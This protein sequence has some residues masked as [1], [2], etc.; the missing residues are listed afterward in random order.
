M[1]STRRLKPVAITVLTAAIT[2]GSVAAYATTTPGHPPRIAT[3]ALIQSVP[4]GPWRLV[5]A[6]GLSPASAQPVFR[7]R[8]G[9]TVSVLSGAG[10]KCLLQRSKSVGGETC[11]SLDAI[12]EGEAISVTDECGSSGHGLMEITGLAPAGV[13]EVRLEKT[14]ATH[15]DAAVEAGA[16]KFEGTNPASGAPYPNEIEWR[17][18][19]GTDAGTATLPVRGDEFCI[20]PPEAPAEP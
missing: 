6:N 16:F 14:D 19:G 1:P 10:G 9:Q 2:A 11:G 4:R 5:R 15:E 17:G 8:N 18:K 3:S 12:D 20:A 7:L 13:R